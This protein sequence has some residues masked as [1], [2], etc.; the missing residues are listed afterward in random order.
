MS[1]YFW[2]P[3]R[4]CGKNRYTYRYMYM[5]MFYLDDRYN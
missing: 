4:L 5:I 3:K 1:W 2:L